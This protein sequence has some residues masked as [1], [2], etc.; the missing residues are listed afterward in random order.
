MAVSLSFQDGQGLQLTTVFARRQPGTIFLDCTFENRNN[1]VFNNFSFLFNQNKFGLQLATPN[2]GFEVRPGEIKEVQLQLIPNVIVGGPT[3]NLIQAVLKN[4]V[5]TFSINLHIPLYVCLTEDGRLDKNEYIKSWQTIPGEN[6]FNVDLKDTLYS[7]ANIPALIAMLEAHNVFYVAARKISE[8]EHLYLS[9]K[10]VTGNIILIEFFF[11]TPI[12]RLSIK[13]V[14]TDL[15][16]LLAGGIEE[17]LRIPFTPAPAINAP[18]GSIAPATTTPQRPLSVMLPGQTNDSAQWF[19]YSIIS[20]NGV[21]YEDPGIQIGFQTFFQRELG[22][23]V[24]YYG[25]FLEEPFTN[26]SCSIA[27]HEGLSFQ[28]QSPPQTIAPKQQ[29]QQ[30]INVSC[31]SQYDEPPILTIAFSFGTRN[32]VKNIKLPLVTTKFVTPLPVTE[33]DFL[34][35]WNDFNGDP[36][37]KQ[38][39]VNTKSQANIPYTVGAITEGFNFAAIP[40]SWAANHVVAAGS[41]CASNKQIPVLVRLELSVTTPLCRITVK[42]SNGVVTQSIL[43]L[44]ATF[45]GV[46]NTP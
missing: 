32:Y 45:L 29:E 22:R 15:N 17:L 43:N 24:I 8:K 31:L 23:L 14:H 21:L 38:V 27:P 33:N 6:E 28:M 1:I 16:A 36:L 4:N 20:N 7:S 18:Q 9:L 13:T 42:S 30:L 2:L 10:L 11:S 39:V 19:S 46:P 3:T 44:L 41:F 12:I 37:E 34:R 25:N 26:I 5:G 35:T 40:G